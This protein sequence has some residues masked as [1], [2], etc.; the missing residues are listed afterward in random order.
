[1]FGSAK[2]S[3]SRSGTLVYRSREIDASR[4]VIQRLDADGKSQ[5]L[6]DKP[7]LFLNPHLSPDGERLAV[8][9]DD[10]KYGIWIYDIRRDTLSPLTAERNGTHPVWTPD[11]QYVVYQAPDG[12]SF[13][14][15]DGGGRPGL[16]TQ[17]KE[18][19]SPLPFRPM[20]RLWPSIK[21]DHKGSNSGPYRWNAKERD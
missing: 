12:I 3:F 16:L 18:L 21:S 6:L 8:A 7:G 9:N 2:L 19:Q 10:V 4:V 11:R 15:A 1:M 14:R 13:A 17:T 5:P 20:A